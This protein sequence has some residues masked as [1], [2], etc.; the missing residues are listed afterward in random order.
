MSSAR[1]PIVIVSLLL[2]VLSSGWAIHATRQAGSPAAGMGAPGGA[3]SA[4][5]GPPGAGRPIAVVS[6]E[7][8][9]QAV[10]RELRALGTARANEAVE[11]TAKTSNIV[12]AI[13]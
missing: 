3:S 6:R 2:A 1:N 12:A 13:R 4:G 10:A 9:L 11:I 7:V 8:S 5:G